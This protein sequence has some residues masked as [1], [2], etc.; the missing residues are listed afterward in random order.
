VA[1]VKCKGTV[2]QQ[3]IATVF[4]AV[5]QVISMELNGVETETFDKTT[6]DTVGAGKEYGQTG[7]AEGGSLDGELFYDP[8]L[9]GHQAITDIVTTPADNDWKVIFADA[10]ATELPFT[11]AGVGFGIAV[12]MS[13]G[14]KSSFSLKLTGLPTFPT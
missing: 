9:A 6:L 11:S 4:T 12:A 13:D 2:L 7:Y 1:K 8:V 14:L 5:A 3:D 10:A